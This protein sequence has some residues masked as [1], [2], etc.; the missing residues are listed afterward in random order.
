VV[1]PNVT[2]LDRTGMYLWCVP[3]CLMYSMGEAG[4]FGFQFNRLYFKHYL[5]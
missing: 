1:K 4:S 5:S 3:L 2:Q